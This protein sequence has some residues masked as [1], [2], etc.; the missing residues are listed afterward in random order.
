MN[1]VGMAA[2]IAAGALGIAHEAILSCEPIK[3]GLTNESW[4]VRTKHDD[5][6][7]RIS[8]AHENSLQIDRES[9]A[10][11]LIRERTEIRDRLLERLPLLRLISQRSVYP[12][13]DVDACT[14]LGLVVSSDLHAGT[15]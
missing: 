3:H 4:L 1:S 9:E 14:Q 8:S 7:V 10:L 11:V 2:G 13:I 12:H 15:P 5:V 6:V